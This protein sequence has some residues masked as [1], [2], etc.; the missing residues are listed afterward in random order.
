MLKTMLLF[1]SQGI[2]LGFGPCLLFCGT[3]ILPA[4]LYSTDDQRSA[5]RNL[6]LFFCGRFLTY[7]LL[8]LLSGFLGIYFFQQETILNFRAVFLILLFLMGLFILFK[9]NNTEQN[10]RMRQKL[11]SG[12]FVFGILVGFSPCIP[13]LGILLE[14][15][16]ISKTF[17]ETFLYSFAFGLGT[18]IN[19]LWL[20]LW[21]FARFKEQFKDSGINNILQKVIGLFIIVFAVFNMLKIIL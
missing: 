8:G 9:K 18:I 7:L 1:F 5:M 15:L 21:G 10:C 12:F 6:A 17:L 16:L 20:L 14:I 4:A 2:I 13:L 3:L 11:N 19:P